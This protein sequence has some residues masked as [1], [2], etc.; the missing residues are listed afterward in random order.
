[1]Q[2]PNGQRE[3]ITSEL[4]SDWHWQLSNAITDISKLPIA[5]AISLDAVIQKYPVKISPYYLNLIKRF[6]CSDPIYQM[7]IPSPEELKVNS[8]TQADPF[9]EETHKPV[10]GIINR[11]K[12]RVVALVTDNCA[13]NCRHCTRKNTLCPITSDKYFEN[14]FEYISRHREIREVLISGGDPLTLEDETLDWILSNIKKNEHIKVIRIGSRVPTTLPMRINESLAKILK[15]HT[16]V[17][18]S[19]HF[20]H[21]R[22]I[23]PEVTKAAGILSDHGIPM[24]NQTVLLK[25]VNDNIPALTELFNGLQENRIK[26]YYA[27]ICD[28]VQGTEHFYTGLDKAVELE[29][30][31]RTKISGLCM[32][33]FTADIANEKSKLPICILKQRLNDK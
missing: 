17:W 24:V 19:T 8:F 31:L 4:W 29:Q 21:Y 10:P 2:L 9:E 32:P 16:P 20:N 23:T 15:K 5:S 18:L 25:N 28:P 7:C 3:N 22:E 12:N 27:F 30:E 11:Y 13:V 26:P 14:I 6:D 33:A 1:M